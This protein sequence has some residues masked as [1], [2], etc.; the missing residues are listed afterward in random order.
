MDKEKEKKRGSKSEIGGVEREKERSTQDDP[1]GHF[2]AFYTSYLVRVSIA[3][4]RKCNMKYF[5]AILLGFTVYGAKSIENINV[6]EKNKKNNK[7]TNSEEPKVQYGRVNVL[8]WLLREAAMPALERSSN[9]A[10]ALH[11][12][13]A[14]G[15]LDC[16]KL[17]V[18]TSALG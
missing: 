14:R 10:M 4:E 11:Y 3:A 17:L 15:C 16:V 9:G 7:L 1:G 2:K 18:E 6:Q 8:R 13:A 12:A 5:Y